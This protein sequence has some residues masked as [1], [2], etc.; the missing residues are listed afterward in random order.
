MFIDREM[1]T[2]INILIYNNTEK[3]TNNSNFL[4]LVCI[5]NITKMSTLIK[6]I[7]PHCII[8]YNYSCFLLKYENIHTNKNTL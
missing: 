2:Y 3:E 1:Q 6:H 8:I 5:I 7:R 4:Y